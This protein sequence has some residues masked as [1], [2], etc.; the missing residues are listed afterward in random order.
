MQG[1][2]DCFATFGGRK[3]KGGSSATAPLTGCAATVCEQTVPPSDLC[4]K[5]S[6][7]LDVRC[8]RFTASVLCSSFFPLSDANSYMLTRLRRL[9]H[10][11]LTGHRFSGAAASR[12][13]QLAF[14]P[15]GPQG[16]GVPIRTELPCGYAT[17]RRI[18][19]FQTKFHAG[20]AKSFFAAVEGDTNPLRPILSRAF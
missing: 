12:V 19:R 4:F 10:R 18:V 13:A 8:R 16:H 15:L 17:A 6:I 20:S 14:Q 7:P 11:S 1:G 2:P 9:E 5:A 3:A